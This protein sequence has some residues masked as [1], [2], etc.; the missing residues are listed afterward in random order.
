MWC[1]AC[2]QEVPAVGSP[3]DPDQVVCAKCHTPLA[4]AR[5]SSASAEESQAGWSQWHASDPFDDSF[6]S[7]PE[8]V[9]ALSQ[10]DGTG[11]EQGD[12]ESLLA[13]WEAKLDDLDRLLWESQTMG[14]PPGATV[15]NSPSLEDKAPGAPTAA[16][17]QAAPARADARSSVSLRKGSSWLCWVMIAAGTTLFSCGGALTVWS[18]LEGSDRWWPLGLP[19]YLVGQALLLA[20]VIVQ[21]ECASGQQRHTAESVAL[22]RE[23]LTRVEQAT[24]ML[25]SSHSP[26]AQSFYVHLAQRASPH[27]LLA[28]LKNQLDLLTMHLAKQYGHH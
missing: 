22:L 28:D 5:R 20:A 9:A 14:D 8:E 25:A 1:E 26:A 7:L 11:Q 10:R 18:F 16:G 3:A 12:R 4:T 21:V 17:R 13:E 2:Q 27:L 15:C 6:A 23:E 24:T 19:L